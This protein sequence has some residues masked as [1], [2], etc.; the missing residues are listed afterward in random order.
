M[1]G[2]AAAAL[3]IIILV[4]VVAFSALTYPSTVVSFPV[5]FTVG[6]AGQEKVFSVQA[7]DNAVDIQISISSGGALWSASIVNSKGTT[8]WT[9]QTAQGEQTT[10][11]SGWVPI[12]SGNYN[13]TFGTIGAGSLNAEVTVKAKGGFW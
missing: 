13:F 9:H 3:I 5:S 2:K 4:V 10:Y 8:M 1:L 12:S 6:A 7:W 11:D